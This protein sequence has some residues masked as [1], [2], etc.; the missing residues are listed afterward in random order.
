MAWLGMFS[1]ALLGQ[2]RR[3]GLMLAFQGGT[4]TFSL[5]SHGRKENAIS[6]QHYPRERQQPWSE[7]PV[8]PV[9]IGVRPR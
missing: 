5:D 9:A 1:I 8:H 6:L 3:T 2:F 7:Q 4:T